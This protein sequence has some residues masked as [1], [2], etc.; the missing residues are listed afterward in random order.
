MDWPYRMGAR[1]T[2]WSCNF[3]RPDSA[4]SS[5]ETDLDAG[6][7]DACLVTVRNGR[8]VARR[9]GAHARAGG[10]LAAGPSDIMDSPPG[11]ARSQRN[12]LRPAA[13]APPSPYQLLAVSWK[14]LAMPH[15]PQ[16]AGCRSPW[17]RLRRRRC[18][19]VTRRLRPGADLI[20]PYAAR[21]DFSL[22]SAMQRLAGAA[23]AAP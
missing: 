17:R 23:L 6:R 1:N 22:D 12:H 10:L 9:G 20:D 14:A 2:K 18:P 8:R 5:V 3:A 21:A 19:R 4:A 7:T 16:R 15:N 11:R 13:P